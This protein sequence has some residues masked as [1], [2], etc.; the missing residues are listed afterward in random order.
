MSGFDEHMV[1]FKL[2]LLMPYQ[3]CSFLNINSLI[4]IGVLTLE[5]MVDCDLDKLYLQCLGFEA[6][7][8]HS[9]DN[10]A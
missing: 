5:H 10:F 8:C 2:S 1:V 4:N 9:R 7:D 3:V 6:L